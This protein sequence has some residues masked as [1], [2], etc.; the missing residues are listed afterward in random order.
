MPYSFHLSTPC[1]RTPNILSQTYVQFLQVPDYTLFLDDLLTLEL[2]LG[3]HSYIRAFEVGQ[4]PD[5]AKYELAIRLRTVKNGPSIR[6]RLKL[7]HAVNTAVRIAVICPTPSRM[8]ELARAAGAS[9]VG[10]DD[11]IDS[12]K[13]GDIN[14]DRLLCV[15]Q[16]AQKLNKAGVGRIL[17]P[18]GL[19]PTTKQ[20][21]IIDDIVRAVKGMVGGSEYRERLG[22]IRLA[23]GQLAFTPEELQRNIKTVM[24]SI[25]KDMARL[26]GKLSKEI[27]EVV[28]LDFFFRQVYGQGSHNTCG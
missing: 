2:N 17:G 5:S 8:A 11:V 23:I 1:G 16:S 27:H 7:P 6:N 26:S 28:S 13:K 12:I 25:K 19:M 18:K 20:G 15:R 10:E 9:I 21:T 24:E 14:F 22:V 4:K 3:L